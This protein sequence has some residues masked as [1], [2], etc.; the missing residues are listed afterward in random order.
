MSKSAILGALVGDAA[1]AT[2]EFANYTINYKHV[3]NSMKMPGG[4]KL[5]IGPGQITDDGELTLTLYS[6]LKG[7]DPVHG[8]PSD[9]VAKHYA[10]WWRSGPFDIGYT[11]HSAFEIAYKIFKENGSHYMLSDLLMNKIKENNSEAN[12]S[13]MRCTPIAEWV[14]S[15]KS[16]TPYVAAEY[17]KYDA[18]LSHPSLVCQEANAVYIFILVNLLRNISVSATLALAEEY[19]NKHVTSDVKYWFLFNSLDIQNINCRKDIGHVKHAFSLA[20]YFLRNPHYSYE[21]AI[22]LTLLQGGDTDTNAAIVGGL[23]SCYNTIPEYM[24]KPV[25]S[26]DSTKDEIIRPKEYCAKYVL[27]DNFLTI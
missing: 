21:E 24:L 10:L 23:V 16:I 1:G 14:C 5:C 15:E 22:S 17:A 27:S 13:L 20:I 8:F 25:I 26:F 4:G 11:T 2:L 6:S 9:Y 19:V 12:G 18:L 3:M 7:Y